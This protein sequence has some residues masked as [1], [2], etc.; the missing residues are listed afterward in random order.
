MAVKD[1]NHDAVL[2]TLQEFKEL[3]RKAFL[4]RYGYG[5]A[6]AYFVL[7]EGERYD[8]KAV[9]GVAHKYVTGE[10]LRSQE[11]GG[12][13]VHVARGLRQLGFEVTGPDAAFRV[14]MPYRVGQIYNRRSD[15]HGRFKGQERGG[16]ATP[17]SVPFVFLFTGESG[18]AYGYADGWRPDGSFAY[19]G[20]GQI[21]DMEFIKGNRAIRDHAEDGKELLLF[22]ATKRKGFHQFKGLFACAGYNFVDANDRE[23]NLRKSIVFDLLPAAL[24]LEEC[25]AAEGSLDPELDIVQLRNLAYQDGADNSATDTKSRV[26]IYRRRS[27]EVKAYVLARANGICE[28]CQESAPFT[29]QNGSPYLEAHHVLRRAD[30]GPD[31]P[32]SVAGIC[33]TC[34]RHIHH[35]VGGVELNEKLIGRIKLKEKTH[36]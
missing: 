26:Q 12:G 21:G 16:I 10:P 36:R 30:D 29:R 31:S 32:D 6:K 24:N 19:T 33:P 23:G 18:E 25:D 35:G 8:S 9:A 1:L 13:E 34:H 20:E 15:I 4:E 28:C 14:E 11:F 3:G 5:E 27:A 17:V 7:H 2:K 22:E